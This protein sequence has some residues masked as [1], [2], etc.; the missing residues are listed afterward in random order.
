MLYLIE[1]ALNKMTFFILPPVTFPRINGVFLGWYG[2]GGSVFGDIA[3][4]ILSSISL[5]A[6]KDTSAYIYIQQHIQSN[7]T[8]VGVAACEQKFEGIA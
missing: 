1:E 5:V 6:H 8:V 7:D 2:I 4:D 3:T